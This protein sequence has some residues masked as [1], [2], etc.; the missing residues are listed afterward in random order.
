MGR[1]ELPATNCRLIPHLLNFQTPKE[2]CNVTSVDSSEQEARRGQQNYLSVQRRAFQQLHQLWR[3]RE[4]GYPGR[5]RELRRS[6][7]SKSGRASEASTW[8]SGQTASKH[9]LPRLPA[10]RLRRAD[11]AERQ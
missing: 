7:E 5:N 2:E 3:G 6:H 10:K 11:R 4:R 9:R 8:P 1:T